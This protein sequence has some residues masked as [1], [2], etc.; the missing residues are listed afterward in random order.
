[1]G[2]A[3]SRL[4][5]AAT[6][7]L[8]GM[9]AACSGTGASPSSSSAVTSTLP[10]T[11]TSA[12]APTSTTPPT[13]PSTT[14]PS[15]TTAAAP[16]ISAAVDL[17]SYLAARGA[18]W[19]GE[20]LEA[21]PA[22]DQPAE[23]VFRV[24]ATPVP[25]RRNGEISPLLVSSYVFL[26]F[27]EIGPDDLAEHAATLRGL[28][29]RS[30]HVS[31]VDYAGDRV[32]DWDWVSA[33]IPMDVPGMIRRAN[34]LGVPVFLE[35]NYSD[36]VPGPVRS[37][38]DALEEA[39]NIA[40]TISFLDG[41]AAEGLHVDGVTFGDEIGD[42][43]GFGSAQPTLES[44]DLVARYLAYAGALKG[45]FPELKIY[46]F[47]SYIA[48]TRGEVAGYFPLLREIR[49]A[50]VREGVDLIDGF[51][52]RES[53]VYADE[54][55]MVLGSQSILDDVESLAGPEPVLRYDVFGNRHPGAD[56]GYLVT[57][58]GEMR[59]I[60]GRDLD[61]GITEYLPA[62][63]VQIDESDTSVYED[64][65]FVI[66]YADLVGT[67]A[68]QGLDVVST[69]MFAN[70]TDQ[71]ECYV[72]KQGNRG[73]NYPVHEQLA[74]HFRGS[75]LQVERPAAYSS[76][77]VKTYVARE[78]EGYFIMVLNKDAASEHTIRLMLAGEFDFTLRLPARSY[79]SLTVDGDGVMVAGVGP[80]L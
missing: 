42:D 7:V 71:A 40:G 31:F 17:V 67:Y 75:I 73:L 36:F 80:G 29:I 21:L 39:D 51:V 60:F 62:G 41:L 59:E 49:K 54:D 9:L 43:A 6:L 74:R 12:V 20:P 55:G 2:S 46:A 44:S 58:V 72:D 15:T 16:R 11:T 14:A 79:T 19:F 18:G 61:I 27:G 52:F 32:L 76:L 63:P 4:R 8:A 10:A 26:Q 30:A 37:G 50:E 13:S 56:R 64:I 3:V 53:Y 45:R 25:N 34:E 66:H 69:W 65:D 33:R 24:L 47:D 22:M 28:F 78:G 5:P 23:G 48:A 35:I 38:L 1:M 77:R 68:E 70:D 57:L